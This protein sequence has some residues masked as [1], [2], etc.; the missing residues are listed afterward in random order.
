MTSR[1]KIRAVTEAAKALSCAVVLKTG[2]PPGVMIAECEC[3]NEN[4]EVDEKGKEE[5]GKNRVVGEGERS[6]REWVSSVKVCALLVHSLFWGSFGMARKILDSS[7]NH[8]I[9]PTNSFPRGLAYL[10]HKYGLTIRQRLRYKNFQMLALE[11]VPP[12]STAPSRPHQPDR[13]PQPYPQGRLTIP[14]GH[15]KELTEMKLLR[16]YLEE[17][18][19]SAWWTAR[20]GFSV[21]AER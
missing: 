5:N 17:C 19:I 7:D 11:R 16:A 8:L 15:V 18:G 6:L 21:P 14:A 10:K 3:G 4:E 9:S 20:M 2:G 12:F 1:K 13:R